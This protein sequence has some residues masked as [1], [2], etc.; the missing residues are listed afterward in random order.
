MVDLCNRL[1]ATICGLSSLA[2]LAVAA[3]FSSTGQ[4]VVLD[5]TS[6]YVPPSVV[7]TISATDFSPLKG[8]C[9]K[10]GGL[11]PL[12]VIKTG[13]LGYSAKELFLDITDFSSADDVY[14]SGFAEGMWC[15]IVLENCSG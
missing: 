1:V 7:A 11:L 14:A 4:T 15:L 5:G 12:T 3:T 2:Q 8:A 6:Y 10:S 13:S 9:G